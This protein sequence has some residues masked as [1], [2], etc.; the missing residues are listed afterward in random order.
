MIQRNGKNIPCTCIRRINII[1]MTILLKA[2]YRLNVI[3]IKI[4]LTVFTELKQIILKFTWNHKRHK[5]AK[6]FLRKK[7][8]SSFPDFKQYYKATLIKILWCR[9]KNRHID[10]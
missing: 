10:Q 6:T 1:K 2:I 9:H 5:I 8:Q 4:P 3:P 7:E